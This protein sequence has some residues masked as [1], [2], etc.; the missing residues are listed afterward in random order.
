MAAHPDWESL[1][2]ELWGR[3]LSLSTGGDLEA[4]LR[5][6]WTSSRL[7]AVA[8][9]S[10]ILWRRLRITGGAFRASAIPEL[11]AFAG[12]KLHAQTRCLEI[13]GWG[14]DFGDAELQRL[15]R[16]GCGQELRRLRLEMGGRLLFQLLEEFGPRLEHLELSGAGVKSVPRTRDDE[17]RERMR[18]FTADLRRYLHLAFP[19]LHSLVIRDQ[20]FY[21]KGVIDSLFQPSVPAACLRQLDL[22]GVKIV[23]R[24]VHGIQA[25]AAATPAL[26]GL[27]LRNSQVEFVW[28]GPHDSSAATAAT[29]LGLWRRLE[30]LDCSLESANTQVIDPRAFRRCLLRFIASSDTLQ[31]LRLNGVWRSLEPLIGASLPSLRCLQAER[32][33]RNWA[34]DI[35]GLDQWLP[36]LLRRLET[37]HFPDIPQ[38]TEI[39]EM[40]FSRPCPRLK[41]LDLS[42]IP[43]RP[44]LL[45]SIVKACPNLRWLGTAYSCLPGGSPISFEE[46]IEL[47]VR[48][49]LM[50]HCDAQWGSDMELS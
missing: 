40:T 50:Q 42:G 26:V 44:Q 34:G 2:G 27:S 25:F 22:S 28:D 21:F 47:S 41:R 18:A 45:Q 38:A 10:P 5:L 49:K 11:I 12:P 48:Q 7:R 1:P 13:V 31:E 37:L 39:L 43:L 14:G 32:R 3:I 6:S 24:R 33:G 9:S 46:P 23:G 16:A 19:R 36:P 4:L 30:M 35:D 20:P 17:H 15:L 8:H 29:E